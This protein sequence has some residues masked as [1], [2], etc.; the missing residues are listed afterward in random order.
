M[1]YGR[2][3]DKLEQWPCEQFCFEFSRAILRPVTQAEKRGK[4][5]NPVKLLTRPLF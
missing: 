5:Q 2:G 3:K 4:I 1:A